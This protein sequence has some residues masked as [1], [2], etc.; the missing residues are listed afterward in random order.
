M[1]KE[2]IL[3]KSL[4]V[5]VGIAAYAQEKANKVARDL[6]KAGHLNSADGKKLVKTVVQEAQKSGA[7]VADV[8]QQELQRMITVTGAKAA[9]RKK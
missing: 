9:K 1:K 4:L 7:R 3:K 6:L 2:D 5:S 8:M